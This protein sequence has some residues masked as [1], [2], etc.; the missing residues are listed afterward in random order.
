M[1]DLQIKFSALIKQTMEVFGK[2]LK[3]GFDS[4][5]VCQ[6]EW[7]YLLRRSRLPSRELNGAESIVFKHVFRL[8]VIFMLVK[9]K[10]LNLIVH[11]PI[12]TRNSNDV[13]M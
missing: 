11:Q 4:I 8:P 2:F 1:V 6:L 5:I 3:V 10:N 9:M 13:R 12:S 7:E